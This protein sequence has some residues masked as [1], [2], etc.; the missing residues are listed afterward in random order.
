M[1]MLERGQDLGINYK[2]D[3][4]DGAAGATWLLFNGATLPLEFWDPV[5]RVLAAQ[6]TN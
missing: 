2:V 4:V 5:V 3:K 1:T 6:D